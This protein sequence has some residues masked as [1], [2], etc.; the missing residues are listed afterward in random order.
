MG[1]LNII[2]AA[3]AVA[4]LA[5]AAPPPPSPPEEQILTTKDNNKSTLPIRLLLPLVPLLSGLV[6]SR[7]VYWQPC[8]LAETTFALSEI[9]LPDED[10]GSQTSFRALE[11]AQTRACTRIGH[12]GGAA[13]PSPV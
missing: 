3:A 7:L 13:N 9:N 10:E 5:A 8:R 11:A 4:G 2:Q 12:G 6:S 1:A